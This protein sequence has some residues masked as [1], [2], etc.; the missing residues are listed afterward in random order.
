[1][2]FPDVLTIRG[3]PHW[4][5][6]GAHPEHARALAWHCPAFFEPMPQQMCLVLS[7]QTLVLRVN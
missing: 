4:A 6:P 7:V 2:P 3:R 5:D 1:V